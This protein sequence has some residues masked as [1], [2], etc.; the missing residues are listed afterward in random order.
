MSIQQF[1]ADLSREAVMHSN[2][3]VKLRAGG[4]SHWYIDH[5]RGLSGIQS[6]ETAATLIVETAQHQQIEYER[7]AGMGIAGCALSLAVALVLKGTDVKWVIGNDD[8]TDTDPSNGYGL[9]GGSVQDQRVL[10][11]D[12]ITSSGDSIITLADMVKSQGGV[13][14]HAMT[15]SDRSAGKAT[16]ALSKLGIQ[17]HTLLVFDE[18]SGR[19]VPNV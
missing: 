12:D 6:L 16:K 10:L 9:H 11:V 14:E 4:E 7:V 13:V 3:P 8:K 2:T 19:L 1:A 5:R 18:K 17:H 15:I